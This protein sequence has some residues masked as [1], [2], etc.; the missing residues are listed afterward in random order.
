MAADEQFDIVSEDGEIIGRAPRA[1]CHGDPSL[2]HRVAHVLLEDVPGVGKTTLAKTL[3]QSLEATYHRIQFTPDLLPADILGGSIYNPQSGEFTFR[4]GPIFANILLADE[5]NRASPRTQSALLEA[6]T[7][8]QATIE[9]VQRELPAPF[10]VVATQNPIE[11]QGTYPLPEAQLDRFMFRLDLGYP[12]KATEVAILFAQRH[13]HPLLSL[14]PVTNCQ[15]LMRMQAAV[16]DV[17]VEQSVAEYIVSIVHATRADSRVRLGASPRASLMLFRAGQAMA[18]LAG[19]DF[20][21]PDDIK[22]LTVP[23]LSHR[24]IMDTRARYSGLDRAAVV[25]EVV[26]AVPVPV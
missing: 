17:G 4:Q 23:V 16:R 2:L 1:R 18:W 13:E 8:G 12:D 26:G 6:M 14:E 21:T 25:R 5:I 10:M 9:G 22:P 11:F 3:A 20:V 19:R 15:T 7:E 24:I